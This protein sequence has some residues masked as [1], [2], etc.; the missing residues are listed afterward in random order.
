VSAAT[1]LKGVDRARPV[2]TRF[3]AAAREA[4]RHICATGAA[5]AFVGPMDSGKSFAAEV[6]LELDC[7][8][9]VIRWSVPTRGMTEYAF[10]ANLATAVSGVKQDGTF[11]ELLDAG[12]HAFSD[13][14]GVLV[15]E[16]AENLNRNMTDLL[17]HLR[18]EAGPASALLLIGRPDAQTAVL[19]LG[20]AITREVT[21][22]AL[23][24]DELLVAV[25]RLHPFLEAAPQDLLEFVDANYGKG[26]LGDWM[27]F[28]SDAV[29]YCNKT[30]RPLDKQA[31]LHIFALRGR[32]VTG[33]PRRGRH[34][35]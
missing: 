20:R 15:V 35:A 16:T 12:G 10:L 31:A 18:R 13:H 33:K 2:A 3:V 30:G 1:L 14:E 25:R 34:A 26:L 8:G 4:V 17:R 5:A 32:A 11:N 22:E 29:P 23:K 24:G 6:A 19:Q 28:A 9:P 7:P 27:N 21:F